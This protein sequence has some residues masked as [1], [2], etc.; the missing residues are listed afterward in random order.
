MGEILLFAA[1]V[2]L[3]CRHTAVENSRFKLR[4]GATRGMSSFGRFGNNRDYA[5]GEFCICIKVR[6]S[7]LYHTLPSCFFP[8][9][10]IVSP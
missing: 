2:S 5:V 1:G 8:S 3:H 4:R 9:A 6:Y 10:S 7:P